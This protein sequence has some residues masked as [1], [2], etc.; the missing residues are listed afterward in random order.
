MLATFAQFERRPTGGDS[1]RRIA[2]DLNEAECPTAQDD[3]RWCAA[4]VRHVL[5]RTAELRR[6]PLPLGRD[7]SHGAS[8]PDRR[9]AGART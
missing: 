5:L 2:D 8:L 3:A 6:H 9:T 7:Q 4:T 1:V